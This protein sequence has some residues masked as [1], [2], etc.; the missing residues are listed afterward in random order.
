MKFESA[1]SDIMDVR[2][3][4]IRD[5]WA[6]L[7]GARMLSLLGSLGATDEDLERLKLVSDG[8]ESDPTL[9]FRKTRNGRICLE[10][11]SRR[12]YRLEAQPFVLSREEDFVRH[13]SETLRI[14]DEVQNDLQLNTAVQAMLA[15][16]LLVIDGIGIAR[17]PRLD[18]GRAEWICTLFSIR[19]LTTPGLLGEPALEGVHSD[20]VDH[21]MTTFLSCGNMSADSAETFLHGMKEVNGNRWH[22]ADPEL[23]RARVQH[24]DFLDTLLIIDHE[25]KHSVSPVY[26]VDDTQPAVR[27]M[28]IF[29]TRKPAQE[30]HV[31]F[32]Y[33]SVVPHQ[34]LPMSFDVPA[35]LP[36]FALAD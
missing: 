17:R 33:D 25:Y 30:G 8:L 12:G 19:T 4:Y 16:K 18:Y 31:S 15:F 36:E 9:P 20:G 22:A 24:R 7:D 10:P 29:F 21:T 32:R 28:L 5:R 27:D 35:A 2:A 26:P 3:E 6:F 11:R 23:V 34:T 1:I 13:D 14:F